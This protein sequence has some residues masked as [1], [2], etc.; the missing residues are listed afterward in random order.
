VKI[1]FSSGL[2]K[3]SPTKPP[4]K[5]TKKP[6]KHRLK[7]CVIG[8]FTGLRIQLGVRIQIWGQQKEENEEKIFTLDIQ[9][10][11]FCN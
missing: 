4:I 3:N 2:A 8:V 10:F 9:I 5:L 6:Q 11:N 7:A 1:L